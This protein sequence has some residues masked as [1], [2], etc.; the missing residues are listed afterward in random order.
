MSRPGSS[1]LGIFG[2][3]GGLVA[4]MSLV[5]CA[6]QDVT[7]AT[8]IPPALRA[9]GN[10]L[11]TR[12]LR[13][14]GVQIYECKA[15]R[16]NPPRF[17]WILDA[18]AADLSDR[19]GKDVGKH[20]AGPTWEANDG[21]TVVGELVARDDG[22]DTSAIPWLLLKAKSN[23][24]KG[25]FARTQSIQRL[26]TVGGLAPTS[27]CNASLAGKRARVPYSADYYFYAAKR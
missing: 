25:L 5:G 11:L 7:P 10:Q 12:A 16:E 3:A 23:T 18:P 4:L 19:S 2:Q 21:S 1:R 9:P 22:P 20:Y 8:D 26:H 27:A 15:S 6:S 14:A 17:S 13:G 24:G